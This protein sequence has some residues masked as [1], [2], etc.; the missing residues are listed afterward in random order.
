MGKFHGQGTETL[1]DGRKY[2]GEW[3]EGEKHGQGTWTHPD[4]DKYEGEFQEGEPWNGK[5][6][7]ENGN[8]T[9]YVNGIEQ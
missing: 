5:L 4:G 6:Y 2:E 3:K 7:D 8:I 1:P 9:V